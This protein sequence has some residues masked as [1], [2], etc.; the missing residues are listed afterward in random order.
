MKWTQQAVNPWKVAGFHGVPGRALRDFSN[1]LIAI[2]RKIFNQSLAQS[3][4]P[5]CLKSSII[6]PLPK[7]TYIFSLNDYRPVVMKC[8]KKLVRSHIVAALLPR[9]DPHQFANRANRSTEDAIA[10]ELHAAPSHLEQ[11]GSCVWMLC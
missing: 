8:F 6:I 4:V 1:Q 2:F 9:L 3:I 7:K 10:T 5:P 11:S